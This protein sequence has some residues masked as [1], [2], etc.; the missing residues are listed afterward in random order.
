MLH[1]TAPNAV[2]LV[3]TS[4]P[5][6]S[7]ARNPEMGAVKVTGRTVKSC[8]PNCT[9]TLARAALLLSVP[10]I[11]LVVNADA[12]LM[13]EPALRIERR[14]TVSAREETSVAKTVLLFML[15]SCVW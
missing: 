14:T 12:R 5:V 9:I 8:R 11:E 3:I 13:K 10:F 7:S 15:C 4:S 2:S 1:T 6:S